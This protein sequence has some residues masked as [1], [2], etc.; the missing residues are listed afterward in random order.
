MKYHSV[1]SYSLPIFFIWAS[2]AGVWAQT[3]G[4]LTV[5]NKETIIKKL[6]LNNEKNCIITGCFVVNHKHQ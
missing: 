6:T 3:R 5:L 1:F 2:I 4:F